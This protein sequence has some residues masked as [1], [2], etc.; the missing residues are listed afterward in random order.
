VN[1]T[2]ALEYVHGLMKFGINPGLERMQALLEYLGKPHLVYPCIHIAG[3]NGKGSVT[4]MVTA[5]LRA[6][7][8]K[9]GRYTSPALQKF[10]ERINV[11]G[12]DIPDAALADLLTGVKPAVEAAAVRPG[13]DHPTEFEFVT[14]AAFAY[15]QTKR[16]DIAVLEAGL[17]GRLDST[18]IIPV[19]LAACI[20]NVAYD[21][22]N[23]LGGT[24]E[25][26][27]AEKAGIIKDGGKVVTGAD[28]PA[29][30]RVIRD[31][32]REKDAILWQVGQDIRYQAGPAGDGWQSFSVST[33][34]RTYENL[35]TQ[36]LGPHQIRNAA[37]AVGVIDSV[38]ESG[39]DISA[40]TVSRGLAEVVWPGR[41]EIVQRNPT[42]VLDGAHN[43]DGAHALR[44]ALTETFK[45]ERLILVLGI[46]RDKAYE[47]M[48]AILAPLAATLFLTKPGSSRAASLAEL[49]AAAVKYQKDVRTQET[50]GLAVEAALQIARPSD[51]VCVAGSLYT[52][53]EARAKWGKTA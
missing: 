24:I 11:G 37:A 17:G 5:I 10:N 1:Y 15:F 32:C 38:A 45:Y 9:V 25:L 43:P 51:L 34:K 13:I 42:V 14:A 49:A 40:D 21:H 8:L 2:E 28:N 7:G 52:I 6:A 3:T 22:M 50:V 31:V 48:L 27:A 46:L 35:T 47:E 39:F 26:I 33:P 41:L 16:V 29:A 53:G 30:L 23:I 12:V 36:L 4:A 19:P 44:R 20:T 18:N